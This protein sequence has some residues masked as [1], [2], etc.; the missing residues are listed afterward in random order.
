MRLCFAIVQT[1]LLTRHE[2]QAG[3][4]LGRNGLLAMIALC[5][6]EGFTGDLCNVL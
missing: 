2:S 5:G 1:A 4:R 3:R 6:Q